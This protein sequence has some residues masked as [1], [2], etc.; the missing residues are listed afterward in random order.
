MPYGC[1]LGIKWVKSK[2][3]KSNKNGKERWYRYFQER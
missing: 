3:L 2:Q 1:T